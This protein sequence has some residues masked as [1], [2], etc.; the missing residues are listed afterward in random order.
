[1]N[2]EDEMPEITQW[3]AK[4]NGRRAC[5]FKYAGLE[6]TVDSRFNADADT[7]N[8][9]TWNTA[10][11]LATMPAR[12]SAALAEIED[13]KSK[14]ASLRDQIPPARHPRLMGEGCVRFDSRGIWLLGHREKGWASFGVRFDSWDD[15]FREFNCRV[16][17]HGEDEHGAYW[18]VE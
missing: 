12:L 17:S 2:K 18:V 1:M 5:S 15:L 13:L 8:E 4:N 14:I 16:T 7:D 10:T 3:A 11:E 6:I 9:I